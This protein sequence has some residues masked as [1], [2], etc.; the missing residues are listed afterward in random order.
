M[1]WTTQNG[2]SRDV[3][4]RLGKTVAEAD[5]WGRDSV[6]GEQTSDTGRVRGPDPLS[7]K[8]FQKSINCF[9]FNTEYKRIQKK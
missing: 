9:P 6:G 7:K 4:R 2:G 1:A 8:G 3:R 5:G